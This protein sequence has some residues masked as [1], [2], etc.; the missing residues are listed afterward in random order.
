LLGGQSF[1]VPSQLAFNGCS[2]PVKSL[3]D[4]GAKGYVFIDTKKAIELAKFY[5]LHTIPLPE[6]YPVRGYNGKPGTPITHLIIM[7]LWVDGRRFLKVP[8]LITDL[9]QHDLILGQKWLAEKDIWL[10]SR[11]RKLL[12]PEER[13][14]PEKMQSQ[15]TIKIPTEILKRPTS[16]SEH[17]KDMERRDHLF[18]KHER[19]LQNLEQKPKRYDYQPTYKLNYRDSM[20]KMKRAFEEAK[21]DPHELPL[22]KRRQEDFLPGVDILAIGAAPFHRLL[23]QKDTEAFTISLHEIDKMIEDKELE[24]YQ[25]EEKEDM[26]EVLRKLPARYHEFV[27]VFSK[28]ASDALPPNRGCDFKI[29]LEEGKSPS[30]AIG[31][32]PLYKQSL[33]WLKAARK[34]LVENLHKGFIIPSSAS[35]ASP[36]LMAKKP[37]GGLRFCVDY[38]KLNAITKKDRYPIPLIDELLERLNRAKIFTKLDIRQGFHRIRM[39]PEAEDLTSFRTRYGMFKYRVL[40]FGLA[41][42]PAAFQRLINELFMDCLDVFLTAYIDDLLIYSDNELEHEIHVKKVLTRLRGAGLQ[43]AIHKCEFHVKRTKYLGFIV[44]SDG[45]EVDPEKTAVVT[46]WAAPSTV[47]G[48]QSFLGFCNFYRRFIKDYSRMAKP[49]TRLTKDNT[50][51]LWDAD[52]KQAFGDLKKLL[53]SAPI[54]RHYDPELPTKIETDAS[55]GVVAGILSQQHGNEWHPIAY[56]SKTMAPAERNY[57]IHDKE[58]LAII[59]ALNEWKAELEGLQGKE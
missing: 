10:D 38:R 51:F 31:Y 9:G 12:W 20:N 4:S 52:C 40:P 19:V 23:K 3:A 11:N 36:I 32:G 46:D 58:M 18:E 6:A 53:I 47:R 5:G 15:M 27:D 57:D 54:L 30:E 39:A 43:A 26:E 59:R 50:P 41:N 48:V 21:Q 8:M 44:S 7:H 22:P 56:F 25:K 49:L 29:E 34:Y 1:L 45:I 42:G 24:Q 28:K 2:T 37:D 17:Q 35:F 55:D 16:N 33:E 13:T 14:Y